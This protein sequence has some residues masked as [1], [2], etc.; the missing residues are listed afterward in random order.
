M[1]RIRNESIKITISSD[2]GITWFRRHRSNTNK[3]IGEN[4]LH[5]WQKSVGMRQPIADTSE[6]PT[7]QTVWFG[8]KWKSFSLL[9]FGR[10]THRLSI[11]LPLS[12]RHINRFRCVILS[13]PHKLH[14]LQQQSSTHSGS[15]QW[16]RNRM[17][18]SPARAFSLSTRSQQQQILTEF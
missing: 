9:L 18:V 16:V 3:Q 4:I 1:Q 17:I 15:S 13:L 5:R 7:T 10:P 8:N 2:T 11:W 12:S 14:S 6:Y